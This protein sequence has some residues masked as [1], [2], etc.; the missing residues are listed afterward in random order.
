LLHL[1]KID[2][3]KPWGEI[4][5]NLEAI[6][7]AAIPPPPKLF[8]IPPPQSGAARTVIQT[9]TMVSCPK[10]EKYNDVG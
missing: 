3:R 10:C 2:P 9:G 5:V 1:Q 7:V 6:E 4:K 8:I